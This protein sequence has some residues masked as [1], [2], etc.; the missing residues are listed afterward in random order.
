[1][2]NYGEMI[3]FEKKE[4]ARLREELATHENILNLMLKAQSF[5]SDE[6]DS[7]ESKLA[8][9]KVSAPSRIRES[10]L[11]LLWT[12]SA[13]A[14]SLD[15]ILDECKKAGF[16]INRAN[17]RATLASWIDKF[18]MAE[19]P[20]AGM[21]KLTEGGASFLRERYASRIKA[22]EE[23]LGSQPEEKTDESLNAEQ[24]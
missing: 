24:N 19:R 22:I 23:K 14:K 13:E 7:E 10:T 5:R 17:A 3:E 16:E 6:L 4:I 15:L 11:C 20:E 2:D 1:M 8:S 21:Y 18:K 12:I 9:C